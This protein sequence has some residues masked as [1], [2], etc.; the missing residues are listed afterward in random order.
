MRTPWLCEALVGATTARSKATFRRWPT[1]VNCGSTTIG[2]AA[3]K[4]PIDDRSA[5]AAVDV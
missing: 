5:A 4:R 2:T 1:A 3:F